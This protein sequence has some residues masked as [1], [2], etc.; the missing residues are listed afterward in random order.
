[1]SML[2]LNFSEPLKAWA[3]LSMNSRA[4]NFHVSWQEWATPQH[5]ECGSGEEMIRSGM[6]HRKVA[7]GEMVVERPPAAS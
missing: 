1:M 6:E 3:E 2:D 4:L 7:Q 5:G